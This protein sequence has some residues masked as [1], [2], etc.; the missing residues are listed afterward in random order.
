MKKER[1][2]W[3]GYLKDAPGVRPWP[4]VG[5]FLRP[6]R[7][8]GL[9]GPSLAMPGKGLENS[10]IAFRLGRSGTS[11][12]NPKGSRTCGQFVGKDPEK[13]SSSADFD[14]KPSICRGGD[15]AIPAQDPFPGGTC[16]PS[17]KAGKEPA[18][19]HSRENGAKVVPR[20]LGRGR[21]GNENDGFLVKIGPACNQV[22]K[23][24]AEA[25]D[26]CR[27]LFGGADEHPTKGMDPG[28]GAPRVLSLP[29]VEGRREAERGFRR[30]S[31][32]EEKLGTLF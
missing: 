11:R 28:V 18:G 21:D 3:A 29:G 7:R 27:G 2:L 14:H 30:G 26:P 5:F 4:S 19:S 9:P 24:G 6:T 15:Q 20:R 10:G 12:E 17:G 16:R 13:V 32:G 31:Q 8:L 25:A 23:W 22:I 1:F